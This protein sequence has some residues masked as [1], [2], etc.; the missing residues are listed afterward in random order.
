MN[1]PKAINT[2]LLMLCIVAIANAQSNKIYYQKEIL[3]NGLTVI[4][5]IDK[6]APVVSTIVHY[7]VGSKDEDPARTGFA[8]FFEHLMFEATNEIERTKITSFVNEVGGDLNAFTS[9]DMTVYQIKVPSNQI[10][11]SLWIE[12]SRMRN[13]KVESLGVETQRGVVKEERRSSTDNQPYGTVF[14]NLLLYTFP[15]SQYSWAPIGS[16]EHLNKAEIK[17]FQDFYNTYYQ[18]NNA[19]LTICGDFNLDSAKAY[20]KEYFGSIPKGKD[21]VRRPIGTKPLTQE[22]VKQVDDKFAQL[23]GVFIGLKAPSIKDK[24][25]FAAVLL[26][27]ILSKGES[28]RMYRK[29][30]SE[31]ELATAAGIYYEAFEDEGIFAVELIPNKDVTPSKLKEEYE[32]LLEDF[33]KEGLTDKEFN[34]VKNAKETEVISG[35]TQTLNKAMNLAFYERFYSDAGLVNTIAKKYIDVKKEDVLNVAKKYLANKNRVVLNYVPKK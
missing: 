23:P 33:I 34:K 26:K 14:E 7:K 4:Y 12:A 15:N 25:Y 13:L 32:D 18:P 28:S 24:D 3:P 19:I 8:H 1:L 5:S 2:I 20:V 21:I 22:L 9:L 35:L 6:S 31:K 17:E 27:D 11:L 29:L 16:Y 10:K 30:V